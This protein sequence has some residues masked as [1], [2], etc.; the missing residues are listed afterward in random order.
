MERIMTEIKNTQLRNHSEKEDFDTKTKKLEWRWGKDILK[1]SM[2]NG[3][4]NLSINVYPE[5]EK[6]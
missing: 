4:V 3:V 2:T 5:K 1:S 6:T